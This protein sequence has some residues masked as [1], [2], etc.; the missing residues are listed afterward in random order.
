METKETKSHTKKSRIK[1]EKN[2]EQG[3]DKIG[4]EKKLV[5]TN[6]GLS[7]KISKSNEVV[8]NSMKTK[9]VSNAL[10]DKLIEVRY[11][12]EETSHSDYDSCYDNSY[13]WIEYDS[14][15]FFDNIEDAW[16]LV[17]YR[18]AKYH[19]LLKYYSFNIIEINPN[20]SKCT[21]TNSEKY[22]LEQHER[23]HQ[24]EKDCELNRNTKGFRCSECTT[25]VKTDNAS[26]ELSV[27]TNHAMKHKKYGSW[28]HVKFTR[29][30]KKEKK[31]GDVNEA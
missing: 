7:K 25:L 6:F 24:W 29:I 10:N 8:D 21:D 2:Q 13:S 28:S 5:Q 26:L 30:L 14:I 1:R 15:A 18:V 19:T 4:M 11:G 31:E 20:P 22:T 9:M 17:Q 23:D 27:Q 16:E 3:S 12:H